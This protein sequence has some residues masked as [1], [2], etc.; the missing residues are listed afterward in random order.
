MLRFRR[1]ATTEPST[2]QTADDETLML[3]AQ[4]GDLDAYN[5][6]VIR[7]QRAVFN[8]C[9]R[10]L[11]STAEAEDAAQDTFLKAWQAAKSFK[12]GV[13]RPWLFR[14]ATNRCYDVLRSSARHPTDSLSGDE[15]HLDQDLPDSDELVNPLMQVE[16]RETSVLL[17]EAL[18]RLSA[19]QRIAVILCDVQRFSYEEAS[20]IIGVPPGTVK[21]RAFRGRER[22]RQS[23]GSD[24]ESRELLAGEGRFS[25][26]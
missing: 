14:I 4:G 3:S 20:Q 22:L 2:V 9:Y 6:L 15:D 12:G 26:E 25:N 19:D 11:G 13:V 18:D 7:H 23:L 1:P 17:Q 10:I 21:S 24:P 16:R 8:V 5:M